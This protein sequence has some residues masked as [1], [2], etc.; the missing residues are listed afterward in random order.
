MSET[1]QPILQL[2]EVASFIAKLKACGPE[3]TPSQKPSLYPLLLS[4]FSHPSWPLMLAQE[5]LLAYII[6]HV[7]LDLAEEIE[8][9][10]DALDDQSTPSSPMVFVSFA[11][12]LNSIEACSFLPIFSNAVDRTMRSLQSIE[13]ILVGG[14]VYK[15][16]SKAKKKNCGVKSSM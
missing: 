8:G 4:D 16:Q 7:E 5:L 2:Q 10:V 13:S 6:K 3:V 12:T 15:K 9:F 14:G 11:I 1:M